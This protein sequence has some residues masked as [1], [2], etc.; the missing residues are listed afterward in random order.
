M[1][2]ERSKHL[3]LIGL[4]RHIMRRAH[5][6][7]LIPPCWTQRVNAFSRNCVL[8]RRG[9]RIRISVK[10]QDHFCFFGCGFF[11]ASAMTKVPF[12]VCSPLTSWLT[13]ELT[14]WHDKLQFFWEKWWQG[15]F[16]LAVMSSRKTHL[17]FLQVDVWQFKCCVLQFTLATS[18]DKSHTHI[19]TID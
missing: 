13:K 2:L 5:A 18:S 3:S 11:V 9:S 16:W 7:P 15:G 17:P 12:A 4:H 6:V 19:V 10:I 14:L 1:H 8:K